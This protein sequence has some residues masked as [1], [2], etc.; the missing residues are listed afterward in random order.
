MRSVER[1]L[2]ALVCWALLG[3]SMT[4]AAESVDLTRYLLRVDA[5][6][7]GARQDAFTATPGRAVLAFEGSA[8]G[9]TV[10][11]NQAAV[12]PGEVTLQ[13][14]NVISISGTAVP[15]LRVRV[16]QP[17]EVSLDVLSRIHFNTDVSDFEAS[18]AFYGSLGFD[19]LSGFPDANTVAMARAIGI[20]EPT[21]YDGS[22]GGEPG[23]YLLHGELIGLGFNRG[24]IDLIQFKIPRNDEPPYPALNRLGMSRAVFETADLDSDYRTLTAKGVRFLSAPVARADGTR[25]AILRDPD[26]TFYELRQVDGDVSDDAPTHLHR[27]G[28]VVINVS[29]LQRSLAWYRMLGYEPTADL[30]PA[31]SPEVAR[32]MGFDAPFEIRGAVLTHRADGSQIELVEWLQPYDPTPPWPVPINHLGIHRMAF[33]SG[34]IEGDIAQLAAQGVELVS[35]ITPCCSG[36]DAWGGIVAFYDPDGVILELAE[37]PIMTWLQRVM[38]LFN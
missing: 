34:D 8:D 2:R 38:N 6:F 21:G 30:A 12:Q 33:T 26:G 31:E 23:G 1:A 7:E 19:T 18:R 17:A 16:T 25:F 5:D 9:L 22:Q 36:P 32:A 13:A 15:P 29:D 37:M 4:A 11:L 20:Y 28:A 27:I 14:E 35:P 10:T 3:L 24:V